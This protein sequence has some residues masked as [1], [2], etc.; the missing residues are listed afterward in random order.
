MN[1]GVTGSGEGG[2]A[3]AAHE[4][5][6]F[7]PAPSDAEVAGLVARLQAAR[8]P[9][10]QPVD[11]WQAGTPV[12]FARELVHAWATTFDF[13]QYRA[14][15]RALPHFR[16]EID[17][18]WTHFL[19]VRSPHRD[20][21]PIVIT[22]GWPSSFLEIVP[23][24]EPLTKPELHGG[25]VEDAFHVVVPSMPGFAYSDAV[26]NLEQLTAASIADRWRVLMARLGYQSFFASGGDIGAR[27]TAWLAVRHPD[28]VRGAHV[29]TNALSAVRTP[30]VHDGALTA[31]E[32]QWLA[33]MAKWDQVDGA[34]HHL[35]ATKPLTAALAVADSPV[36]LAA[37]V[38]EKWQAWSN[39]DLTEDSTRTTLLS[40]LTLY[41]TTG[42]FGS[43]VM[44]YYA[45]DLPPGPRPMRD[46][47]AAPIAVYASETEIGGVPP[48]SL[49]QRQ[50]HDPR[51]SVLPRGG[52]FM[53]TEEPDLLAQDIREFA[54]HLR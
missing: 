22:H 21:R 46:P 53:A 26:A 3:V 23:L 51:W 28:A 39:L 33:T 43:S 37:W 24:L 34:Y 44:H 41:W 54:A 6:V 15:L 18:T 36:A 32:E 47:A 38:A 19:H 31:E 42:S 5:Q 35:Q 40:L 2:G 48:R 16:V 12:S 27:V 45:H 30:G 9:A 20:A 4:P 25:R 8:F 29:S 1:A 50:Y 49:A 7:D 11:D 10:R 14:E 17:G 13:D 52:H